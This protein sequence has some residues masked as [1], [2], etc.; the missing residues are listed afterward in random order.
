MEDLEQAHNN[1]RKGT[2]LFTGRSAYSLDLL[3]L[4]DSD[5]EVGV[6]PR[7]EIWTADL[8]G[9]RS[10][11]DSR[12]QQALLA[13]KHALWASIPDRVL[14]TETMVAELQGDHS[15]NT[16]SI[17]LEVFV[18]GQT[19]KV[20]PCDHLFHAEC[21]MPWFER[22]NHCPMCRQLVMSSKPA[23]PEDSDFEI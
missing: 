5:D 13:A 10:R 15:G 23:T 6:G 20:L 17:C 14:S 19:L 11:A 3:E 16:C 8:D 18:L 9:V 21:C 12:R 2:E 22:K 1:K 7:G 4:T